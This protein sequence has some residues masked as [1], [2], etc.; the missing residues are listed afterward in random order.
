M[1]HFLYDARGHKAE[2]HFLR[3]RAGREVDFLITLNKKPWF[4]VEVKQ[5]G[6]EIA[7]PLRYFGER[8]QIP[9]LYQVALESNIDFIQRNIRVMSAEKFLSGLV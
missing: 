8:L 4:A 6:Q 9:F 1:V 5:S 2:L 7:P 3:D